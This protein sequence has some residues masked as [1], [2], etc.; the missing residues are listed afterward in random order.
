[1]CYFFHS[2]FVTKSKGAENQKWRI[3]I[4]EHRKQHQLYKG[5]I[6][7]LYINRLHC[8]QV[9]IKRQEHALKKNRP[10]FRDSLHNQI[11]CFKHHKVF[12]I[13]AG[14]FSMLLRL[15]DDRMDTWKQQMSIGDKVHDHMELML[16]PLHCSNTPDIAMLLLLYPLL[17]LPYQIF[18]ASFVPLINYRRKKI[19]FFNIRGKESV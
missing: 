4:T 19:T 10:E 1:M 18:P 17:S 11:F 7:L 9:G 13:R 16:C 8:T 12:I 3:Y 14:I 15:G 2:T 5:S 6:F